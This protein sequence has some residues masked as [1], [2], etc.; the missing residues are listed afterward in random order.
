MA[1]PR[2]LD[3]E[4]GVF[5]WVSHKPPSACHPCGEQGRVAHPPG[6]RRSSKGNDTVCLPRRSGPP[7]LRRPRTQVCQHCPLLGLGKPSPW[8]GKIPHLACI[9]PRDPLAS[10]NSGAFLAP[11]HG[12]R[13]DSTKSNLGLRDG[14][15]DQAKRFL[16]EESLS[17][18]ARV[19]QH[20]TRHREAQ[21]GKHVGT[22][23][24]RRTRGRRAP[25][26]RSWRLGG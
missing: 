11:P 24:T 15:C 26:S 20:A 8:P 2:F 12:I 18:P 7:T 9:P 16:A 6:R 14:S 10:P 1:R 3:Q 23:K 4:A 21:A 13:L 19:Y 17:L 22:A 25:P 5:A